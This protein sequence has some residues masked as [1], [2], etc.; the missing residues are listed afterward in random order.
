MVHGLRCS[1]ACGI[2]PDQG[3]NPCPLHWQADSQ[4][5]RHQGSPSPLASN[6]R[7]CLRTPPGWGCLAELPASGAA[8][9][10]RGGLLSACG[11]LEGGSKPAGGKA[12]RRKGPHSLWSPAHHRLG[13]SL[14][15]NAGVTLF[16][17]CSV[18]APKV[19]TPLGSSWRVLWG[20][21]GGSG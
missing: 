5:L 18:L 1:A 12:A 3:L 16:T 20:L 10:P 11:G 6:L 15:A 9:G 17:Y 7:V 2:F 13:W 4:P 14:G 19:R 21:R 8:S